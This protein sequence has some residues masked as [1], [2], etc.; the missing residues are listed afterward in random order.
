MLLVALLVLGLVGTP[1]PCDQRGVAPRTIAA[2]DLLKVV[3]LMPYEHVLE[4][5]GLPFGVDVSRGKRTAY[6][7]MG[8]PRAELPTSGEAAS[9]PA[10]W[11]FYTPWV[12]TDRCPRTTVSVLF[13]YGTVTEVMVRIDVTETSAGEL[14]YGFSPILPQYGTEEALQ[15]A[16]GR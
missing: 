15:R 11:L 9:S 7:R 3:P 1:P 14:V 2:A 8:L 6:R 4:T 10:V 16:L 12:F 13:E 5:I